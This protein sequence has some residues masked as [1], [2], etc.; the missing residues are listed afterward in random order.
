[1]TSMDEEEGCPREIEIQEVISQSG[2]QLSERDFV[3]AYD[4]TDS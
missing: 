4:W 2:G 3:K 1:M